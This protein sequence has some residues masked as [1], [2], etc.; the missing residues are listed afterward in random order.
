M[1]RT[2]FAIV[3]SASVVCLACVSAGAAAQIEPNEAIE[4]VSPLSVPVETATAEVAADVPIAPL[5]L[6]Q[7][8]NVDK[9]ARS[10]TQPLIFLDVAQD[11]TWEG[12]PEVLKVGDDSQPLTVPVFKEVQPFVHAREVLLSLFPMRRFKLVHAR[13]VPDMNMRSHENFEVGELEDA[14]ADDRVARHSLH[15]ADW[16][17]APIMTRGTAQWEKVADKETYRDSKGKKH[18]RTVLRWELEIPVSIE[19]AVYQR[20]DRDFVFREVL[21]GSSGATG[22]DLTKRDESLDWGNLRELYSY[23]STDLPHACR[24]PRDADGFDE[25]CGGVKRNFHVPGELPA[26]GANQGSSSFCQGVSDRVD[27]GAMA[28]QG[29][30]KCEVRKQVEHA[31]RSVKLEAK[32]F[33]PWNLFDELFE[34]RDGERAGFAIGKGRKD[35]LVRGA[36]FKAY[37]E[38]VQCAYKDGENTPP[39]PEDVG[40]AKVTY[41]GGGGDLGHQHPSFLAFRAGDAHAG[42][43]MREYAMFGVRLGVRAGM[44]WV[45]DAGDLTGGIAPGAELKAAYDLTPLLS[46][47]PVFEELSVTTAVGVFFGSDSETYFV[48]DLGLEGVRYLADH[49]GLLAALDVGYTGVSMGVTDDVSVSGG[50]LALQAKAGLDWAL[51]P[52]WNLGFHAAARLGL[53]SAT[54]KNEERLPGVEVGGGS[55]LSLLLMADVGY[56]F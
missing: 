48:G 33:C 20:I 29:L 7:Y 12:A 5:D 16:L 28:M 54:L 42:L 35:G 37:D 23:I 19:L 53:G 44:L 4:E 22:S 10:Q 39:E 14:W 17:V 43:H 45:L 49:L 2:Y 6:C 51:R 56:T 47:M 26:P 18:E 52:E 40:W 13:A 3:R 46:L 21:Q 50:V 41:V 55:L 9:E 8:Q 24:D 38:V 15:C 1:R 27:A 34:A 36:Y 25:A 32:R 11:A 30:A 31:V